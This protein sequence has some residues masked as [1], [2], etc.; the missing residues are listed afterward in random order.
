MD[1]SIFTLND[2]RVTLFFRST[3]KPILAYFHQKKKFSDT[4]ISEAKEL[5]E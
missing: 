4:W 2:N 1:F 3:A 5:S